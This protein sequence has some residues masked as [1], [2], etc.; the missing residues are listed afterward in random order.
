MNLEG[1]VKALHLKVKYGEGILD[2]E[3]RGGY[4]GDLLRDVMAN[5]RKGDLLITRQVHQNIVTVASLNEL[6]GIV[7]VQGAEPT[8]ETLEK[9]VREHICSAS[10]PRIRGS[11]KAYI[12]RHQAEP[13]RTESSF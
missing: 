4:V 6:A 3:V 8:A 2:I 9:T 7:L 1:I 5:S 10:K 11:I 12:H 13:A